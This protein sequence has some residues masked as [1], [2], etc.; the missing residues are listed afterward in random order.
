MLHREFSNRVRWVVAEHTRGPGGGR[1]VLASLAQGD[2]LVCLDDD[3][4]PED[5]DFFSRLERVALEH[6]QAAVFAAAVS[7]PSH[8]GAP[9]ILESAVQPVSSFE[10]SGAVIRREEFLS[11]SGY[12]PLRHA[13]GMEETDVS[14]QLLD[15]GWEILMVRELRVFHDSALGHHSSRGVNAAHIRNI[16]LLAFLRYPVLFWPLGFAQVL[17]RVRYS[18]CTRRFNGIL[19]GLLTIPRDCWIYRHQRR[20]V[21]CETIRKS[22]R[23]R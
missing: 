11:T 23:L 2:L 15:Q 14:L 10:N 21:K 7:L 1:N 9:P 16:G 4:W 17:N 18:I 12:L 19:E 8:S 13:Y 3:S 22:R 5:T 6:P 20:P